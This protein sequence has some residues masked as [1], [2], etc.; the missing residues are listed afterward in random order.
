MTFVALILNSSSCNGHDIFNSKTLI[1]PIILIA[2]IALI[3]LTIPITS[4]D[5]TNLTIS[6]ILTIMSNYN[7]YMSSFL[8]TTF[9]RSENSYTNEITPSNNFHG[10]RKILITIFMDKKVF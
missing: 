8:V 3:I 6:T 7:S 10:V 1:V 2:L 9:K 5:L 4:N